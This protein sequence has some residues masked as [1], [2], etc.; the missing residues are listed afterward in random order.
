M[1]LPMY[2]LPQ[3]K[4]ERKLIMKLGRSYRKLPVCGRGVRGPGLGRGRLSRGSK[5]EPR[6][7]LT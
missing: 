1:N 3:L 5:V 2:I 7:G 6:G 4:E